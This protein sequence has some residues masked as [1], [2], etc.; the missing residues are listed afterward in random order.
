M[1]ANILLV[2]ACS[3]SIN[4]QLSCSQSHKNAQLS[5]SHLPTGEMWGGEDYEVNF[6]IASG[7]LP[8]IGRESTNIQCFCEILFL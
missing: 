4:L 3:E 2:S 7:E 6:R 1:I 8:D 5:V